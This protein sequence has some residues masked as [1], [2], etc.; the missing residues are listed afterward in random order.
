MIG[1]STAEMAESGERTL[2]ACWFESLA[3]ASHPLQQR[4]AET[5]FYCVQIPDRHMR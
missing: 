5:N 3:V 2:A 4:S 1:I